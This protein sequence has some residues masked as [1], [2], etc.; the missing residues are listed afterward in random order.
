MADTKS[1]HDAGAP[2]HSGSDVHVH[3]PSDANTITEASDSDIDLK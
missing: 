3:D 2:E 1:E